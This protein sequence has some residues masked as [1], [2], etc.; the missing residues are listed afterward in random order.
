[1]MLKGSGIRND[2]SIENFQRAMELNRNG[3]PVCFEMIPH[4]S[5]LDPVFVE[6]IIEDLGR[7]HEDPLVQRDAAEY[8]NKNIVLIGHKVFLS[9][10]RRV[11]ARTVRSLF[12]VAPKYRAGLSPEE[13]S[14][15]SAHSRSVGQ[16]VKAVREHADYV[17]S[18]CPEGGRTVDRQIGVYKVGALGGGY[19]VPLFLDMPDGFLNLDAKNSDA[20]KPAQ[21]QLTVGAPFQPSRANDYSAQMHQSL[22]EAGAPVDRFAWGYKDPIRNAPNI[23]RRKGAPEVFTPTIERK[24]V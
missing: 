6:T 21:V 7:A 12:T 1:M 13:T 3:E 5:E 4:M 18:L 20:L 19:R 10:I 22:S 2:V 8:L 14:L 23:D 24:E 17:L 9:R 11:F 15:L 16:I